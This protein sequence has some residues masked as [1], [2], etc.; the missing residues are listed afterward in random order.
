MKRAI[1]GFLSV[2]IVIFASA[3][4]GGG[5]GGTS[6][7]G[8]TNTNTT[9]T[10]TTLETFLYVGNR[11]ANPQGSITI[12]EMFTGGVLTKVGVPKATDMTPTGIAVSADGNYLYVSRISPAQISQYRIEPGGTLTELPLPVFPMPGASWSIFAHPTKNAVYV[13]D[14]TNNRIYQFSIDGSGQLQPMAPAFL[15]TG[16]DPRYGTFHPSGDV[17]Y[18]TCRDGGIVNQFVV[19]ADGSLSPHTT[20]SVTAGL[21]ASGITMTNNGLYAYVSNELSD[22]ISMYT[23][24]L[25]NHGLVPNGALFTGVANLAGMIYNDEFFYT[26]DYEGTLILQYAIQ[27]TGTLVALSPGTKLAGEGPMPIFVA[28]GTNFAYIANQSDGTIWHYTITPAGQLTFVKSYTTDQPG[29]T[30]SSFAI[31]DQGP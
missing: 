5:G 12:F 21:G 2:A 26:A 13:P 16:S 25:A 29:S 22:N 7:N 14:S 20:P 24:S 19:N 6:T 31:V 27:P 28:P 11:G 8:G 1:I 23:V 15:V 30:P 17:F 9:T 4:G 3:C 18:L 10:G